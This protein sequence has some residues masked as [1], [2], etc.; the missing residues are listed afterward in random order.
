MLNRLSL[1]AILYGVIGLLAVLALSQTLLGLRLALQQRDH[2]QQVL[3]LNAT[4]D[5]LL[6][7]A[8]SWAAERGGTAMALGA[9]APVSAE[10]RAALETQRRTADAALA[11]GRARLQAA[12]QPPDAALARHL[13]ALAGAEAEV[14][15]LRR[16]V[17]TALA[18]PR[19]AREASLPEQWWAGMSGLIEASQ[20]LR[21]AQRADADSIEAKL[22]ELQGLKHFTWLATEFLG[23]ERGTIAGVLARGAPIPMAQLEQLSV[24]RGRVETAWGMIEVA[25]E[26]G[27]GAAVTRAAEAA[28]Q[29]L[30]GPFQQMRR[31][32]YAAGTAG[33]PYPVTGEQWWQEA[34]AVIDQLRALS[35]AVGA[36]AAALAEAT[37]AGATLA[38]TF[39]S[40]GLALALAAALGAWL[41]VSRRVSRPLLAMT[42]AMRRLAERDFAAAI[43][44]RDRRDEIG[45]MAAAVQ[46]FRESM[47]E[48]DRLAEAQRAEQAEKAARAARVQAMAQGFER[49][50]GQLVSMLAAAATELQ[51]TAQAMRQGASQADGRAGAV[52]ASAAEASANVE[53]VAA[54][55]EQL[56]ASV[57]EIARQ[58]ERST[59]VSSRAAENAQRTDATVRALS[60]AAQRIGDV[61]GLI[62][63]IAGQ[64]NLL[65]LNAT[66]EA[67]R[68][69]EAGKGFAVVASEVK[70]LAS[71]TAR[72]TEEIATQIGQI[73]QVTQE[74]VQAIQGIAGTIGEVGQIT[75]AIAA[76]VEQQG[77]ATREIARNVQQA[78]D[79][80]RAVTS[81]V[82]EV[83][84]LVGETGGAAQDVLHAAGELSRQSE[85]LSRQVADFLSG[86]K[87]A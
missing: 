17:D 30:T 80:T 6:A 1:R 68:A 14:A 73:Q 58:V 84:Q 24:H 16:R 59:T 78:A 28:R 4:A 40:A 36:E 57:A 23:R 74:A 49:D 69:G 19:A 5:R 22:A 63:S 56:A 33:Q 70:S 21:L 48:G 54:A 64:T 34:T 41:L 31:A 26:H 51:G 62:S 79:G 47:I 27:T 20:G 15:A 67:A 43:P 29:R 81:H 9:E 37:S 83:S 53:T 85:T 45:A 75:G 7:A 72:A 65:A 18:Q 32:V 86:L 2:A 8:G 39:Y 82:R 76:A 52:A 77:A 44:G 3:A 71:Q 60:A 25:L 61:V 11:E 50:A 35:T 55:A 46:V 42:V 10:R 87:A 13:A 66:I 12:G 38:F